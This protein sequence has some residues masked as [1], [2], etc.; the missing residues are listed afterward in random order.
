[1]SRNSGRFISRETD[2]YRNGD[3]AITDTFMLDDGTLVYHIYNVTADGKEHSHQ[4]IDEYGR[5]IYARAI[6]GDHPWIEL[7]RMNGLR[8]LSTLSPEKLKVALNVMNKEQ[9]QF[10][11]DVVCSYQQQ[12]SMETIKPTKKCVDNRRILCK[13]YL[14]I[15]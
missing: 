10:V 15:I 11:S 9:L 13:T 14:K 3:R 8:W 12:A 1:M 5:H 2:T 7:D 4:I 6:G